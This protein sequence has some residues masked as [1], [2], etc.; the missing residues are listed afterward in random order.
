MTLYLS[1]CIN[2]ITAL[3]LIL[4]KPFSGNSSFG[5]GEFAELIGSD[6]LHN[7][8]LEFGEEEAKETCK[9]Q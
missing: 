1:L 5:Q 4:F 6:I 9:M 2:F 8:T 3:F 7:H